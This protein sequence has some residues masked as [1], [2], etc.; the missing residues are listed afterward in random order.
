MPLVHKRF[1]RDVLQQE[2]APFD[3]AAHLILL[4]NSVEKEENNYAQQCSGVGITPFL[5]HSKCKCCNSTP[6]YTSVNI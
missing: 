3:E 2:I 5:C 4:V 1:I 6:N